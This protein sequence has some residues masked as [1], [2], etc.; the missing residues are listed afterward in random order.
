M[1][2]DLLCITQQ[3]IMAQHVFYKVAMVITV[4]DDDFRHTG[5]RRVLHLNVH[6]YYT[7]HSN[8]ADHDTIFT[9]M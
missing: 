5:Y 8:G 2:H 1:P 6:S 4:Q 3:Q 9:L 7:H